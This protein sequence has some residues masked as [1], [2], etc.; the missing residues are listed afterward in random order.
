MHTLFILSILGFI[1]LI[2]LLVY[3]WCK[4]N[5]LVHYYIINH[6]LITEFEIHEE[7]KKWGFNMSIYTN[8]TVIHYLLAA[9]TKNTIV[10]QHFLG[11]IPNKG[12]P[13]SKPTFKTVCDTCGTFDEVYKNAAGI[14][15]DK[16]DIRESFTNV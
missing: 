3:G 1:L 11:L 10:I 8:P 14:K 13:L 9:V 6:H 16:E 15:K 4:F 7:Y 12:V 5:I 2:L